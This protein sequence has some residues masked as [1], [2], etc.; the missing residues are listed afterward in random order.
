MRNDRGQNEMTEVS[1]WPHHKGIRLR[2]KRKGRRRWQGKK[3][4]ERKGNDGG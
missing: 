1:A 3:R 2:K 4:R